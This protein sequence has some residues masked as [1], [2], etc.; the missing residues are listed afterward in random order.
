M[1]LA[2]FDLDETLVCGDCS[3]RFCEYLERTGLID[4]PG[5]VEGE[6]ALMDDYRQQR[7]SMEAYIAFILAPLATMSADQIATLMPTFVDRCISDHIYPQALALL[8]AHHRRGDRILIISASA[9]FIV[10]AVAESLGVRDVLAIDLERTPEGH[11]S[12]HIRGVPSYR[13][14]KV[15]RLHAWLEQQSETL[16]GAYFYSDSIND[17]PLLER[18]DN[19]VAT[20]PDRCL[21]ELANRRGWPVLDWRHQY[22][23][24]PATADFDVILP[25]IKTLSG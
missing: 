9:D 23:A 17:L 24:D 10:Q 12:G 18:V 8:N 21:A 15:V 2:I 19:P 13:E 14:G 11:Y 6:R 3:S 1:P 25:K 5:F 4:A 22:G 20:N 7:L 16:A